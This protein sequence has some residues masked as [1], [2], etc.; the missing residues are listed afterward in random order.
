MKSFQ[1]LKQPD[2]DH[3]PLWR[4]MSLANF[5]ALLVERYLFFSRLDCLEDPLE[6]APSLMVAG[7]MQSENRDTAALEERRR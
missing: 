6:G 3:A 5:F 2:T 7:V 1:Y 4:Y